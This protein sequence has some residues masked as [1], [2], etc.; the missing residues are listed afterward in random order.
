MAADW[1]RVI[2]EL[3]WNP[4]THRYVWDSAY[5]CQVI[6]RLW[7][8]TSYCS[9]L[10]RHIFNVHDDA[11]LKHLRDDNL[12]IEPEWYMPII[13]MVLVNGAEGIGTGWS[14]KIPNYDIR[15]IVDNL[16]RLIDGQEPR[17]MVCFFVCLFVSLILYFIVKGLFICLLVCLSDSILLD[18]HCLNSKH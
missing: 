15:T 3:T 6:L 4:R 5:L 9:S 13:P 14:T 18:V 16:K 17:P 11:I 7:W 10:A 2:A 12:K 8:V 1:R